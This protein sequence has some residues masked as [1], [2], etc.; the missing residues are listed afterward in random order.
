MSIANSNA[1]LDRALELIKAQGPCSSSS[2][3][4]KILALINTDTAMADTLARAMLN[5]D[6]RFV[7]LDDG[8]WALKGE[9]RTAAAQGLLMAS[10]VV[11]DVETTGF[12]PPSDRVIEIGMVRVQGG[13]ITDSYESLIDPRRPVPGPIGRLTGISNAMLAGQPTFDDVCQRVLDFLG[14][15]VFVA[16]NAP[17]DWRFVQNEVIV[18]RGCKLLNPRLCT[19]TLSR[20]LVPELER[21]N[22]DEVAR[23]FNLSFEARHRALGDAEV[24]AEVLLRLFERATERGINTLAELIAL[25]APKTSRKR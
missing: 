6:P 20:R 5:N 16:H 2:I 10:Y 9:D 13:R 24:T 25:A 8:R 1:A 7:Q 22:L 11:V 17:F 21:R 15:S 18:S 12:A 14:D 4:S 19:A 3:C 23:F